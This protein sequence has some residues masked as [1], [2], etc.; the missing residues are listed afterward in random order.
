LALKKKSDLLEPH[1]NYNLEISTYGMFF[2]LRDISFLINKASPQ[3]NQLQRLL[4]EAECISLVVNL[5]STGLSSPT[6]SQ[7]FSPLCPV[8]NLPS[9][10][11]PYP[12]HRENSHVSLIPEE[13]KFTIDHKS[14]PTTFVE[15]LIY[16][17]TSSSTYNNENHL[18]A[19]LIT[20][21]LDTISFIS[22]WLEQTPKSGYSSHAILSS[23]GQ[24]LET[25]TLNTVTVTTSLLSPSFMSPPLIPSEIHWTGFEVYPYNYY[26]AEKL[27][28]T[29]LFQIIGHRGC[30]M[31]T[32]VKGV[33][34]NS[35]QVGENTLRS[36]NTAHALGA[37]W[38]EFGTSISFCQS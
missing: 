14:T 7:T 10:S 20:P 38:V 29:T 34:L 24:Y 36:F 37:R 22:P 1:L 31:N 11:N 32:S 23:S 27:A 6:Q 25:L 26:P 33:P 16:L 18:L 3:T 5:H 35:L 19:K 8:Q 15:I 21:A 13:I 17:C 2:I 30:G 28:D 9:S 12:P 4:N